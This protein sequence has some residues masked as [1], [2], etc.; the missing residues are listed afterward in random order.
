MKVAAVIV[1]AGFGKRIGEAKATILL[2]GKPLF[3]YSL[4]TFLS[5]NQ[6]K[7]II[8]VLQKKHFKLAKK[9]I[10]S[11]KIDLVEGAK[12]RKQSVANG[13]EKISDDLDYVLIHDCARP[14]IRKQIVM[15]VVRELKKHPAVVPGVKVKDTLKQLKGSLVKKTLNRDNLFSIQTPQGFKKDLIKTAYE[16]YKN[17]SFTDSAQ[18]IEKNGKTVKVVEGDSLNFKLTYR[19]DIYLAKAVGKYGKI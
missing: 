15:K 3:Y 11:K 5:I 9:F 10:T 4:K 8:L 19:E 17:S 13:L 6:I 14:F 7:Q 12:K 16:K 1:C 2:T 18:L